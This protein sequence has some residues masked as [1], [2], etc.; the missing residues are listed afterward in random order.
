MYYNRLIEKI[1]R[2]AITGGYNYTIGVIG[3]MK[4]SSNRFS[5]AGMSRRIYDASPI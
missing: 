4:G 1:N 2:P 5:I 3:V